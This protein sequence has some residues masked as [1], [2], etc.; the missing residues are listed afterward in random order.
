MKTVTIPALVKSIKELA[1]YGCGSLEDI[2]VNDGNLNYESKDGVLFGKGGKTLIQ[3]SIGSSATSYAVPNSVTSITERAFSG[4]SALTNVTIP[5]SVISIGE[6]AFSD[7]RCL[8][9][10]TLD[11]NYS[12]A[13]FHQVFPYDQ[14]EEII[15]GTGVTCI[16]VWAFSD[17]TALKA[18]S[19]SDKLEIIKG[20]A[21]SNC[22]D[23]RT[24]IISGDLD[25]VGE[26]AFS[27]CTDLRKF[28][29]K[30][31]KS[32]AHGDNV[33]EGCDLLVN[34]SVPKNIQ[35]TCFAGI[36]QIYQ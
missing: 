17:C 9:S 1:F 16:D 25:R 15:I 36:Q 20:Y 14:V 24:I 19:V 31:T 13:Q 35:E 12:V 34:V 8:T 3:Y 10:V 18:V 6:D 23:L 11:S 4:C 22:I 30:G 21:F 33:F 5:N 28:T 32:P 26:K 29:Y 2:K 27:G 7:C